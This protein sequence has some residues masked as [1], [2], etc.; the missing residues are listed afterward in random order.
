MSL[1]NVLL[2]TFRPETGRRTRF[3]QTEDGAI[4][5]NDQDRSAILKDNARRRAM[6]DKWNA[7]RANVGSSGMTHIARIPVAD[8]WH[9]DR[10][11]VTRDPARLRAF[12][13]RPDARAFRVD[14]GRQL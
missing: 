3:I 4:I 7:Y 11:G 12:L 8:W 13:N 14:D 5:V 1:E 2:E 9:L 10:L 6:F